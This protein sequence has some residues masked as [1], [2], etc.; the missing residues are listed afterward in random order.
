ML[1]RYEGSYAA[2]TLTV[3]GD[4]TGFVWAEPPANNKID[5]LAAAKWQR[6]KIQPSGLS[7]DA[8][9]LRRVYLD[10]TGLPPTVDGV[11]AFLADTRDTKLKRDEL[12]DKL[13]GSDEYVEYWSNKWADLLQVNGKFLAREGATSFRKWIRDEITANTPY[14]QFAKKVVTATGSNKDVPQAASLD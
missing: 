7:S 4:R 6:M 11:K 3:M 2:T 13:V 14:D 1:V 12:I 5:T 8:E 9:F 10:L